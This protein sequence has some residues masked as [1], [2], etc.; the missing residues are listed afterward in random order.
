MP[1]RLGKHAQGIDHPHHLLTA[2][3]CP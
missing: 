3:D 2:P 1:P